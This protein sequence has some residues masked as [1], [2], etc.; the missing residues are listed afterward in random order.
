MIVVGIIVTVVMVPILVSTAA[1]GDEIFRTQPEPQVE[2]AQLSQEPEP[3]PTPSLA[4]DQGILLENTQGEAPADD[5]SIEAQGGTEEVTPESTPAPE[6]TPAVT[7]ESTPAPEQTPAVTPESTPAPEQTPAMTPESTP[8]PEQTPAVTPESTPVPEQTPAVTPEN[9]PVPEQT[10]VQEQAQAP[11]AAQQAAAPTAPVQNEQQKLF[12]GD[13][14]PETTDPLVATIQSRLMSLH[15]MDEDEPTEFF[16]PLTK[17]AIGF[18]QRKHGFQVTGVATYDTLQAL[19]ADDAKPYTVTIG[20]SGTDVEEI[21]KRL[22]SLGYDVSATG[23][24]GT[25]TEGAVKAFQKNNE[26]GIDGNV[27]YY[28]KEALYSSDAI[29]ASGDKAG[30][31][32]SGDS[33]GGSSSSTLERFIDV[34]EA[35]LGKPYVLGAKGPNAFDCSGLI[36]YALNQ[37]GYDIDYMTSAGWRSAD[38]TTIKSI[39][40]LRR[41]DIICMSGHVAVYMGDGTVIDASSSQNAMMHRDFGS[42]FKNGFIHA[43]RVF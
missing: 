19:F 7:P 29:T 4:A 6:Q 12:T 16:G 28:T 34:L 15:Y 14:Q 35:Q 20:A 25:D 31:L 22:D 21:Q 3:T 10:P 11:Q 39:G 24:F 40:D 9:T 2:A 26:L 41:G 5:S 1:Y 33:S 18:F 42:W 38:F 8:A 23:Y 13:I 36:Y 27:G 17:Q 32:S 43:K 37:A 30:S